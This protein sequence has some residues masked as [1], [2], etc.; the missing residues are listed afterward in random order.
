MHVET[1][2]STE[3][4][5]SGDNHIP[6]SLITIATARTQRINSLPLNPH[7]GR[8]PPGKFTTRRRRRGTVP[9]QGMQRTGGHSD[10]MGSETLPPFHTTSNLKPHHVGSAED[11]EPAARGCVSGAPR[12]ARARVRGFAMR[13]RWGLGV[14]LTCQLAMV[15]SPR[16]IDTELCSRGRAAGRTGW[17][18]FQLRLRL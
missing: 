11:P 16:G 9:P 12:A 1:S 15:V 2:T 14:E 7:L 8:N 6:P 17:G 5:L 10:G 3:I 13:P 18:V 4:P